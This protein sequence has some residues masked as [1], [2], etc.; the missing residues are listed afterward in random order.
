[1]DIYANLF[2]S[3]IDCCDRIGIRHGLVYTI[4]MLLMG[5]AL[6]LNLLSLI[7]LLWIL[8]VAHNP[9][10]WHGTWH[11][12]HYVYGLL[13]S[14]FIANTLLGRSKFSAD[15][16]HLRRESEAQMPEISAPQTAMPKLSAI[17]TPGFA[18]VLGSAVFFLLTLTFA[19]LI[20]G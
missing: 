12:H 11:P 1:M 8:G 13:C 14:A 10:F 18:Y 20:R 7:D 9:Y 19:L 15:C 17:R 5:L 3:I 16:Q 4:A 2:E 6:C